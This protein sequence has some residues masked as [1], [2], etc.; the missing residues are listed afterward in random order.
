MVD[1]AAGGI[2]RLSGNGLS[3]TSFLADFDTICVAVSVPRNSYIEADLD[4]LSVTAHS[5]THTG[6]RHA[7]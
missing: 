6:L 1:V 7:G 5:F 4:S 2:S 3:T